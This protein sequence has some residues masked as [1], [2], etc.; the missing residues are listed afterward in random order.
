MHVCIQIRKHNVTL[1]VIIL[2]NALFL[3]L[4][5]VLCVFCVRFLLCFLWLLLF[6]GGL[7]VCFVSLSFWIHLPVAKL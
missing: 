2:R 6:C 3:Y 7:F 5:V 1:I 4:C